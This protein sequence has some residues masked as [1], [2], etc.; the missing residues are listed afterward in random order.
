MLEAF[1]RRFRCRL[2]HRGFRLP[3]PA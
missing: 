1:V 2:A 3:A